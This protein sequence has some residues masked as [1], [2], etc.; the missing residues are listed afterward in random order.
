[1]N[2]V[3]SN[4][5]HELTCELKALYSSIEE[6]ENISLNDI[7]EYINFCLERIER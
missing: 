4:K 5:L 2:N 1:M 7:K 6:G 3:L